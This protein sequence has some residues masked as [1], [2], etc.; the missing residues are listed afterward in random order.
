MADSAST[1]SQQG[2][3][4]HRIARLISNVGSPPIV[5]LLAVFVV[6]YQTSGSQQIVWGLAYIA[7]AVLVPL[8]YVVDLV[9]RGKV[10]DFHLS[11]REERTWP[12]I[13]TIVAGLIAWLLL[14]QPAVALAI[15]LVA[16]INVIQTTLLCLITTQWKISV[17]TTAIT[18]LAVLSWYILGASALFFFL[19]I[20][21]IAWSR[22]YLKRHT[23]MQLVAGTAL[24]ATLVYAAIQLHGF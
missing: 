1:I 13:I 19:C 10:T 9:R 23:F 5:G 4:T 15:Q 6:M 12:F 17:H 8:F 2:G 22:L 18:G 20:P 3:L 21:L 11:V 24:G 7:I 14:R 16:I